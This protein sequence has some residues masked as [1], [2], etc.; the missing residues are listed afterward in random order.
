MRDFMEAVN[1]FEFSAP[2][3]KAKIFTDFEVSFHLTNFVGFQFK[4]QII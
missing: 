1:L 4:L 2:N 3:F